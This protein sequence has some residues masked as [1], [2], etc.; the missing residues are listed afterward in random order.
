VRILVDE[1]L[2]SRELLSRLESA[3]PG[4]VL[5][6]EK[7]TSDEDVWSRAQSEGAAILTG[8]VVDFLSLAR[9]RSTHHGLLLVYR[10]NDPRD[11]HA[12]GIAASVF[13]ITERYP[14]GVDDL[15]LAVNDYAR[16]STQSS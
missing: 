12:A 9:Q 1:D 6:P 13:A 11:L 16:K 10:R 14:D 15:V 7:E 4:D 8:N 3:L 2:A 5:H